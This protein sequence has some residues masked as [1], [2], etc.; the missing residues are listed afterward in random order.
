[1][2]EGMSWLVTLSVEFLREMG[3]FDKADTP[4]S[5]E[6]FRGIP[7]ASARGV[8][9]GPV[10][11][12]RDEIVAPARSLGVT[13]ESETLRLSFGRRGEIAGLQTCRLD[14]PARGKEAWD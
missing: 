11:T 13:A 9:E 6:A 10:M 2:I 3:L 8:V 5:I 7:L 14:I 4:E 12:A 1:M